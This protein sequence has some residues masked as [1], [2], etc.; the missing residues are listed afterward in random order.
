MSPRTTSTLASVLLATFA[1]GCETPAMPTTDASVELPDAGPMDAGQP[2]PPLGMN[3]VSIL[4][5]LPTGSSAGHLRPRDGGGRGTLLPR[6]VFDKM[7]TFPATTTDSLNYTRMLVL[8]ARF[9]MCGG[10]PVACHPELRL[11][12]Q[13]V[14][15]GL[16]RDSALHL[17][18]R[19]TDEDAVEVVRSLRVLRALAP[20]ATLDGA[21]DVHP[22]LVAQGVDGAYG[23]ALRELILRFAGEQNLVRVTFFL[24]APPAIDVWFMGGFER[25]GGT[26][27]TMNIV[28]VGAGTQRVIFTPEAS[29][30]SY[31]LTPAG[32]TPEDGS[33]LFTAAAA[34]VAGDTTRRAALA[35]YARVENPLRHGVDALPC[36]SCHIATFVGSE[37]ARTHGIEIAAMVDAYTSMTRNLT[38]RGGAEGN[39]AS[40][41]AFGWFGNEPMIA[42]RTVYETAVALDDIEARFPANP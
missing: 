27:R 22:A 33:A 9:D 16:A 42:R 14:D 2:L 18:Y 26:L 39:P 6:D 34:A 24:R 5:P 40:M 25:E 11:V 10:S 21:L 29:G 36:G 38:V 8:S 20:E 3:D 32:I 35:S 4:F 19:L 1:L 15:S 41:R 37:T 12:M 30:Y 23:T 17:F 31:E 7:P 28:G 13:P